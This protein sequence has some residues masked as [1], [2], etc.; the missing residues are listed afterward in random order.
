MSAGCYDPTVAE[1]PRSPT[2]APP[3]RLVGLLVVTAA[4]LVVNV[5]TWYN[6]TRLDEFAFGSL[7][8][9][10]GYYYLLVAENLID[11]KGFTFDGV[12]RTSGFQPLYQVITTALSYLSRRTDTSVFRWI[13]FANVSITALAALLLS[14]ALT[15]GT[16]RRYRLIA[17]CLA[18]VALP[19]NLPLVVKR[20]A[21]GMEMALAVMLFS[22]L[23]FIISGES[24][25]RR[26][27]PWKALEGLVLGA[28]VLTRIDYV[29]FAVVFAVRTAFRS[30][31]R[32]PHTMA[33][34]AGCVIPI[35]GYVAFA[36]THLDSVVPVS[37]FAKR[38]YSAAHGSS[39]QPAKHIQEF[40]EGVAR[41]W[42]YVI[43][44]AGYG[45]YWRWKT[46]GVA[47][48]ALLL[49]GVVILAACASG[50]ELWKRCIRANLH[51]F[52]AAVVLHSALLAWFG[53]T[54]I[55]AAYFWY[56]APELCLL[57]AVVVLAGMATTDGSRVRAA[58]ILPLVLAAV[59]LAST[60]LYDL[61]QDVESYAQYREVIET[62]RRRTEPTATLGS[63]DAGYNA[64]WLRPRRV[65]N[66]DGMMNSRAYLETVIKTGRMTQYLTDQRIGYL[67]NMVQDTPAERQKVEHQ[68]F[69]HPSIRRECY[70]ILAS[71]PF[72]RQ[73]LVIYLT[74]YEPACPTWGRAG[75]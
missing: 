25:R 73:H 48:A 47:M 37:F 10:D 68:S 44:Y 65:V 2:V 56:Y 11:G 26:Q 54:F 13:F 32:V 41:I 70:D 55:T 69:G 71:L 63:W 35:A 15:R 29:L 34:A 58:R 75:S 16:G 40:A 17:G 9:D 46:T 23:L 31:A 7:L 1:T 64:Y 21:G 72:E 36:L 20:L 51:W 3:R 24:D 14:A 42:S 27:T 52:S 59:F 8:H 6:V 39:L 19:L 22:L 43:G 62:V 4:A 33:H 12:N 5:V 45:F 74:R 57:I 38:Y 49:L 67:L 53:A 61:E 50:R 28:L 66:L 18:A 60:L 30:K